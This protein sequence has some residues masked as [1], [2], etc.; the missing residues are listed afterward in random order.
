MNNNKKRLKIFL[1]DRLK[2]SITK[3][4]RMEIYK[5]IRYK[6]KNKIRYQMEKM[7]RIIKTISIETRIYQMKFMRSNKKYLY[8][9]MKKMINNIRM[10]QINILRDKNFKMNIYNQIYSQMNQ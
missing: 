10:V 2:K 1:T 9:I 6:Q 3:T 4:M 7:N 5:K 8:I